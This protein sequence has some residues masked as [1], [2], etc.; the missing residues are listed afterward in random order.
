M[1]DDILTKVD[2]ATMSTSLEG[3]EPLLDHRL[4]E[5]A[6]QLPSSF[7][8]DKGIKKLLLTNYDLLDKYQQQLN[9]EEDPKRKARL[10]ME[11]DDIKSKIKEDEDE[12]KSIA[13][14]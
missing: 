4:V 10:K 3:R 5:F 13:G 8:Y 9:F 11:I 12:L 1:V 7:K 14:K 6:A 2:R